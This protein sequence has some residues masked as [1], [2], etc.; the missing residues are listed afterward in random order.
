MSTDSP[1]LS[2][3]P[4]ADI[5]RFLLK[6]GP[7]PGL[8]SPMGVVVQPSRLGAGR[9]RQREQLNIL[10]ITPHSNCDLLPENQIIRSPR[11]IA[12]I[13]QACAKD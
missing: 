8:R 7:T 13:H 5:A 3:E 9:I 12:G 6:T 1:H 10:G 11:H 2:L 4:D